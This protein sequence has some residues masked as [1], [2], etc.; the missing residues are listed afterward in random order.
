MAKIAFVIRDINHG[1]A[2]KMM[3]YYANT[4]S[5][6]FENVSV[7]VIGEVYNQSI[8]LN[9]QIQILRIPK[10]RRKK[11]RMYRI[12]SD[13]KGIREAV[14]KIR[15]DVLMPFTSGNTIFTYLSVRSRYFFIGTERGNPQALP[16]RLAV[17]CRYIYPKC[18]YMLFQSQGAADY[19]FKNR[20]Y[21]TYEVIPNPCFVQNI[22]KNIS[23]NKD[24]GHIYKIVS[25]SRLAAEK[26]IDILLYAFDKSDIKDKSEVHIYGDGNQK[27]RL[28]KLTDRLG[29]QKKV[30]FHGNTDNTAAAMADAD[31]FVLV[32]SGE[33]MPNALI[34]AMGLG[35]PCI[36]TLCMTN[37]TNELITDGVNGLIVKKKDIKGLS[38]ALEKLINDKELS[39]DISEHAVKI[40]EKLS[41][42]I[43]RKKIKDFYIKVKSEAVN[44]VEKKR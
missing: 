24:A 36:S 1:G 6:V 41:E 17:L 32:S 31:V 38:A 20:K 15:P 27:E 37:E 30:I 16:F 7:I 25:V 26:N 18:S 14:K 21:E 19:Y 42:T 40:R 22:R 39:A 44:A 8:G 34:E 4:A 12:Y 3:T 11:G 10:A 35:I 13:I 29:L 23:K 33:G 9:P 5:E 2:A 43:I 28:K